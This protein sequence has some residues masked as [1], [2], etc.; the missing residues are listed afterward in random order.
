MKKKSYITIN[1]VTKAIRRGFIHR[2]VSFVHCV[3]QNDTTTSN[4]SNK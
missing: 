3:I 1:N 2:N 4:K